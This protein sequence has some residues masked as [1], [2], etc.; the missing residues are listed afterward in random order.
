MALFERLP[1]QEPGRRIYNIKSPVSL[2][3][4]GQFHA[5]SDA[6]GQELRLLLQRTQ[7]LLEAL[8]EPR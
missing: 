6:E 2:E 1:S 8:G 4:I 5:A 7:E 3:S